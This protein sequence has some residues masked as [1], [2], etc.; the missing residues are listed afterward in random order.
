MKILLFGLNSSYTHTALALHT[1][2]KSIIGYKP[3]IIEH[4]I[5]GHYSDFLSDIFLYAPD[6]LC[7]SCY[8]WNI[9]IIET[10]LKDIKKVLPEVIIICGGPE[11][12]YDCGEFL[13]R[14]PAADYCIAG[15]GEDVFPVIMGMLHQHIDKPMPGNVAYRAKNNIIP[16]QTV[17]V[18]TDLDK[19]D[20]PYDPEYIR[21][22]KNKIFYCET[23]RGCPYSC[24]YCISSI[25]KTYRKKSLEK[26]FEEIKIFSDMG[27][28]LVKFTD[29]TFNADK[30]RACLILEHITSMDT[31]TLFHFEIAA[32]LLDREMIDI[33]NS[34][35]EGRVQLE[36][37]I[38]TTNPETTTAICRKISFEKS[39]ENLK[40]IIEKGNIHVHTDLIAGLPYEDLKSF[41][42]SFNDVYAIGGHHLQLGFLKLLKGTKIKEEY[43]QNHSGYTE[44]PPYEILNTPWLSYEDLLFLKN[45]EE[46]V[47]RFHNS[48]GFSFALEYMISKG[49]ISPFNL[50]SLLGEY[51]K[52]NG[53]MSRPLSAFECYDVFMNFT[54][55][56]TAFSDQEKKVILCLVK[57]D[58]ASSY[59]YRKLPQK[60]K[61]L[62]SYTVIKKEKD[63]QWIKTYLLDPLSLQI[64][65]DLKDE[66]K[67][68]ELILSMMSEPNRINYLEIDYTG[69]HSVTGRYKCKLI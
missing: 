32:D 14:N 67:S 50:F 34:M 40:K 54:E 24:S 28:K 29:R 1:L 64:F 33:L 38:Q 52:Q 20:F 3:V 4:T 27:V 68:L 23:S 6:V 51:L 65:N 57:A 10:L 25:D 15:E 2:Q 56:H 47:E 42:K 37:G 30:K 26:V 55:Q 22:N 59:P 12:S 9:E 7:F 43:D 69:K 53:F 5:N 19:L 17:G 44:K 13:E 16:N 41:E 66:L 21:S 62:L 18:I 48:S 58:L 45:T 63:N 61:E 46:A 39:A 31:D 49:L 60:Y 36:A 8:I 11:V 35:P